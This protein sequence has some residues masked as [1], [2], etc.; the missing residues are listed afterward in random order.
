M[1]KATFTLANGTKVEIEGS[2]EEIQEL[3]S[4]YSGDRA[5]PQGSPPTGKKPRTIRSRDDVSQPD[6]DETE[7]GSQLAQIVN[8]IKS[9]DEAELIETSILDRSSQVDRTLLPLYIVHKHLGE[10]K[11][12]TSGEVSKVTTDLGVPISGPNASRTLSGSASKYVMSDT[13][14]RK[15]QRVRYV[16]NRRGV[17]Y[18]ESVIAGAGDENEG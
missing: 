11:G 1:T 8:L 17:Q 3:L 12:L 10:G 7:P 6:S 2:A 4:F 15:G 18:L 9:C 14:R 16:L 13:V 5:P